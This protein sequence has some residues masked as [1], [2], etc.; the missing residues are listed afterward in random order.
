MSQWSE[1]AKEIRAIT[2]F[3]DDLG[4]AKQFYQNVFGLP[5]S[6]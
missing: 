2:P 3:A 4:A 1:Q 5:V 6:L